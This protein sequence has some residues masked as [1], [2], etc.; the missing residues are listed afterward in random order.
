MSTP[1]RESRAA[2]WRQACYVLVGLA[3]VQWISVAESGDEIALGDCPE[4]VRKT[5]EREAS[6]GQVKE[7]E[8]IED[9]GVRRFEA[10]LVIDGQEYE[11]LIDA[12]GRLL[13]KHLEDEGDA[14]E[15][16]DDGDEDDRAATAD[17]GDDDDEDDEQE[18][19]LNLGDLPKSVRK[20]LKREA[21][22]GEIEEIEREIEDGQVCYEAEVE[23]ETADGELVYE[24][25]INER[26]VLISKELSDEEDDDDEDD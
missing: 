16:D 11:A 1:Q 2:S 19:E 20:T 25:E 21:R 10:D 22:G 8:V 13:W 6:G 18:V 7:V 17:D 3:C 4:A 14:E 24:I 5:I 15:Q 26:G 12:T 23:F 9:D